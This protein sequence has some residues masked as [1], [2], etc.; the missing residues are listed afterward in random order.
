MNV[1]YT[2][3]IRSKYKGQ[4][5][6]Q[7]HYMATEDYRKKSSRMRRLIKALEASIAEIEAE[8]QRQLYEDPVFVPAV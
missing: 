1:I 7:R 3:V 8:M 4:L 2:C 5:S 6:D